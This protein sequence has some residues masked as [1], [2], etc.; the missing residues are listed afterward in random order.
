MAQVLLDRTGIN[1]FVGQIKAAGMTQHLR[2]N[3]KW[4]PCDLASRYHLTHKD[5]GAL[6]W[7]LQS[8]VQGS[9]ACQRGCLLGYCVKAGGVSCVSHPEE[10]SPCGRHWGSSETL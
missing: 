9:P 1:P 10:A 2:M 7:S 5:C 8:W 3:R 4:E 6:K